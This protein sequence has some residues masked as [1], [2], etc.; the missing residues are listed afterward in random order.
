VKQ[1]VAGIEC[2]HMAFVVFDTEKG[3]DEAVKAIKETGIQ[4]KGVLCTLE[5]CRHEPAEVLWG[6]L[7]VTDDSRSPLLVRGTVLV[8]AAC[9]AWTFVLYLPYAYYMASFTYEHGN[10]PGMFSETVFICL[11][12]GS[13]LG[14]F[15]ASATAASNARF[16]YTS[17]LQR[18]FTVYYT[19][20]LILNLVM[21]IA[22]Q[23]YLSYRQMVGAGAHTASGSLLGELTSFQEV[24]ESYPMQKSVGKLLFEYCW[25]CTF[26]VPFLFELIFAHWW[27]QHLAKLLVRADQRIKGMHAMKAFELSEMEQRRYADLLFNIIL[28]TCIPFISPAYLHVTLTALIVSH[29]FIYCYDHVKVLRYVVKFEFSSLEVHHLAMQ[30]FSI[31]LGILAGALVLKANQLTGSDLHSCTLQGY[32]LGGAVTAAMMGHILLHLLTLTAIKKICTTSVDRSESKA[33]YMDTAKKFLASYF[34]LSPV[35]CL[36]SRCGLNQET[37]QEFYSPF[38]AVRAV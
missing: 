22:L 2:E 6:N 14:V 30:L 4:I 15:I 24:F 9:Q 13:Q 28:V 11:V 17:Q 37:V 10:E 1:M 34:S 36:R 35:H 33:R 21:D 20:A 3:R 29:L 31:P 19:A 16:H 12:V 27:P 32:R 8:I 23:G 25:P 26:L 5:T 18:R 38:K 7:C